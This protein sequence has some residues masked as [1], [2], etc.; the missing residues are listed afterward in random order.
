MLSKKQIYRRALALRNEG[1]LY[2]RRR[3]DHEDAFS[4][5][6]D[7]FSEI[8]S[9]LQGKRKVLDVGAGSGMLVAILTELGH[10]CYVADIA[11][12]PSEHPDI[13]LKKKIEFNRCNI[14]IDR[15]PYPDNFF[16]AVVTCATLEH[17]THSHLWAMKEIYRVIRV[18][19]V[20]A[21]DVP[22]AVTFRNRSRMLRGKNITW[23]Y[24]KHYLEAEPVVY[25][26]LSFYP[27]RHN[28]EFT[29]GEL[30]LLLYKSDF[31]NVEVYFAKS[32]RHREGYKKL[33][34]IGSALRDMVP[35]LRKNV[36]G[37]GVKL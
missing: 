27:D 14:E 11:E 30:R 5:G 16:D 25:K 21:V 7:R 13:F 12:L 18:E 6:V 36:M 17:F 37:F 35:S 8:A 32:R 28:R 23:D 1:R 31:K 26:G 20:V 2:D 15:L 4:I 19:G 34:S 29:K 10:E 33:K 22:N 9:R 24:E 3:P